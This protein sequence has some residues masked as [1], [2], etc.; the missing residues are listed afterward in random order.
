MADFNDITDGTIGGTG[1]FDKMMGVTALHLNEE[2]INNRITGAQYADVYKAS[3]QAA[4]S[5]AIQWDLQAKIAENQ[6]LLI[7]AQILG[8]EKQNALIDKQIIKMDSEI[9]VMEA[10]VI[11]KQSE[12]AIKEYELSLMPKQEALIDAQTLKLQSDTDT[13]VYNLEYMLPKQ[14]ELLTQKL[15]TEEA[16]TMD[17]TSQGV[18]GG[19]TGKQMGVYSKQIDGYDR[20]AEQKTARIM[21]DIWGIAVSAD[22]ASEAVVEGASASEITIVLDKMRINTDLN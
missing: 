13:V 1:I 10:E 21:S 19:V 7:E 4:M 5:Q 9:L 2:F 18:V 20:D 17:T 6:A 12:A 14:L 15:V 22:I 3:I 8:Q 16:Q 11:L